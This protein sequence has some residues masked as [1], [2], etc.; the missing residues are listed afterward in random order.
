MIDWQQLALN[1]RRTQSLNSLGREV[2]FRPGYL[3]Q[4]A[5]GEINEPKFSAG[6]VLLDLHFDRVGGD[7]HKQLLARK[8]HG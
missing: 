1:L 8:K 7:K 3:N 6:L 5:R 2:G 4:L